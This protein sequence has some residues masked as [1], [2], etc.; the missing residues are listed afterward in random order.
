MSTVQSTFLM[1]C[2]KEKDADRLVLPQM[3][4]HKTICPHSD[5]PEFHLNIDH[6]VRKVSDIFFYK[7]LVDFTEARLHEATLNLHMHA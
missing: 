6:S 2:S 7:N 3:Q 1:T 4:N 5:R